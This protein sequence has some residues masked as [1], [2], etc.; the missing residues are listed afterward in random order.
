MDTNTTP[1]ELQADYPKAQPTD[2]SMPRRP[3][4]ARRAFV[5]GCILLVFGVLLGTSGMYAFQAWQRS[6]DTSLQ[7]N[8]ADG[9]T[10]IS[11]G[12]V[13][14]AKVAAKV[15][16]SVVSVLTSAR[17]A[18]FG[19]FQQTQEGAGTGIIVSK[20]GYIMTNN[21][22]IDNVDTVS[23][24]AADGTTYDNVK[25]IGRD[26]LNDVA[27]LKIGGVDNLT[28]AEIGD[29]SS[30]RIGQNVVAIGNA[31]GQYQNTVTSGI[32]SG[33]GRPVSAQAGQS[34][35]SLT[36]LLQTDAAINSGNSGGPLVNMAGQVVGINTAVATNANGIGF[37]IPINSTKG[38]LK[39][40]LKNGKVSRAY[41]GVNYVAITPEVAK[42]YKLP[43]T[44]GAYVTAPQSGPAVVSGSPADKAGIKDKDIITK[45]DNVE[46]GERGGVSSI[47]GQYAPGETVQ[48]T[49]LRS[50]QAM[51]INVT[52]S[53]YSS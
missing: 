30:I 20:D 37:A 29:S 6:Q 48:L 43:V 47:V 41:L 52:L 25:V 34:V 38:V 44:K 12:E 19:G 32:I 53:S 16:P 3:S 42:T 22:V 5:I 31:L 49:I 36:D 2:L 4:R 18:T 1:P 40:V 33:T 39:G 11:P 50:G 27:F 17:A 10:I 15:S 9:N 8:V 26:P 45:V 14:I 51:T 35:E 23:V 7:R 28:P 46:V 13:D 24:V 21:H